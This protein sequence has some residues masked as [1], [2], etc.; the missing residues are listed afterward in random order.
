MKNEVYK[1]EIKRFVE[2]FLEQGRQLPVDAHVE[3]I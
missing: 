3:K 1:A 2:E